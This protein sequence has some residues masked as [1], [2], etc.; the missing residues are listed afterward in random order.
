MLKH[1][2]KQT[3]SYNAHFLDFEETK[4]V[5][6]SN[7]AFLIYSVVYEIQRQQSDIYEK[8]FDL[9]LVS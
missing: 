9:E 8:A 7:S 6:L 3:I 5:G 2:S 4:E 1:S